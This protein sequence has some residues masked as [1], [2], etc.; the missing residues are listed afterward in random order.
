MPMITTSSARTLTHR[1]LHS[2]Q[3]FFDHGNKQLA[4]LPDQRWD[5]LGP[6]KEGEVRHQ[7]N[8]LQ[9]E[10]LQLDKLNTHLLQG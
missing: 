1:F 2:R 7:P 8:H 4:Q 5:A 3:L 6:A 10:K 9:G